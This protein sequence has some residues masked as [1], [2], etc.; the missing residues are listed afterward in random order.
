MTNKNC[1]KIFESELNRSATSLSTATQYRQTCSKLIQ[2]RLKKLVAIFVCHSTSLVSSS[3]Q[4]C[5]QLHLHIKSMHINMFAYH[6][7]I[8]VC[9]NQV[10]FYLSKPGCK[11]WIPNSLNCFPFFIQH[12]FCFCCHL[13]LKWIFIHSTVLETLAWTRSGPT[14][15]SRLDKIW[16]TL[17]HFWSNLKM[18]EGIN[19]RKIF[20]QGP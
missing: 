19:I 5:E 9:F 14:L 4:V 6:I 11:I 15:N 8:I 17:D 16:S 12:W 13:W 7:Y 2:F 1:Y 20:F 3:L 18:H 10:W